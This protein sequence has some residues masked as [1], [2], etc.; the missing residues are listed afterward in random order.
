MSLLL[1]GSQ[2]GSGSAVNGNLS[3]FESGIDVSAIAGNTSI[4]GS[5]SAT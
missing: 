3:G 4:A 2:G 5:F 1:A